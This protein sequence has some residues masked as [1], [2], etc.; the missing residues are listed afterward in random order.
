MLLSPSDIVGTVTAVS[1]E[2]FSMSSAGSPGRSSAVAVGLMTTSTV[3]VVELAA[4]GANP[5]S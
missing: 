3:G 4:V 2:G 5:A 1:C